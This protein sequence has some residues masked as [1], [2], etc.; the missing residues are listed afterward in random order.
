[1]SARTKP[2]RRLFRV[3]RRAG[4]RDAYIAPRPPLPAVESW[5]AANRSRFS[6]GTVAEVVVEHEAECGYPR[7][8][9]CTCPD[10]P[11]IRVKGE[12]AGDN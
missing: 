9:P 6:P 12:R 4:G 10:G 8:G 3:H 5:L 2:P 7:G 1:M 11:T